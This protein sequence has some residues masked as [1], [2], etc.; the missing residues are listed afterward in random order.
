MENHNKS[1][2]LSWLEIDRKNLLHNIGIIRR[3]IG[4]QV[5]ICAVVKANA[6]GHGYS[7][8][9]E[10]LKD[11]KIDFYAVHSFEEARILADYDPRTPK[12]IV[13]YVTLDQLAEAVEQGFHLTVYN[14]ESIK[15]LKKVKS[16][17]PARI[18][19]K[20]ETGTNRQGVLESDLPKFLELIKASPNIEL[21]GAATHYANIEDTTDHSY[22]EFQLETYQR[23]ITAI[24][25]AGFKLQIKHTASSAASLL[26]SKTHYDMIRFGISLYGLWP[27]K[28]TYLSYRLAGGKNNLLKPALTWKTRVTQIKKVPRGSFIGYGCTYRTTTDSKIAILPIGYF[29]GYDRNISNLGY[30]LIKGQR[31]PVRGRVCMD[32]IMVDVTNIVG[33]GLEDEVVLLG[34]QDDEVITA[35]QMAGWAQTINYEV[36]SRISPLL[37]RIIV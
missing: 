31:A 17:K 6:Y 22:A 36:I 37:P 32:I 26:F 2:S 24:E 28:E 20:L 30:V 7:T 9:A 3:K 21:I 25:S 13:G 35:E 14:I 8:I 1:T 23:M 33:V 16:E 27:S 29:D 4:K 5:K 18:H 19:L 11:Q 10:I 12:L 15:K 34:R